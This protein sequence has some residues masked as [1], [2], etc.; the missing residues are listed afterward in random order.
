MTKEN[1]KTVEERLKQMEE[2]I[3]D[4]RND[5]AVIKGN[6]IN[7]DR[8]STLTSSDAIIKD[9]MSIIGTSKVK[10][11][12]LYLTREEISAQ[13]L[14]VQISQDPRNLSKF[15]AQFLAKG[16]I[17]EKKIG[18]NKYFVRG[19]MVNTVNIDSYELFAKMIQTRQIKKAL[20]TESGPENEATPT[21]ITEKTD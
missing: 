8:V 10:A 16:Y 20:P 9:I 13:N 18:Q 5:I 6:T 3:R 19:E 14:A 11:A 4:M 2:D 12:V 17:A 21:S 7:I 1:G 15:T